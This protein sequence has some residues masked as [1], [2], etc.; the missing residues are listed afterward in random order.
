MA[1]QNITG[2]AQLQEFLNT[3]P[4]KLEK[5]IMRSALG[6]GARAMAK[7][8]RDRAPVGSPSSEGFLF[9]G[10]YAG[11]LRDSVRVYTKVAKDGR[12][13]AGIRVGG[14]NKKT[15]ADVFYAHIVEFGSRPHI[16]KARKGGALFIGG[17][18]IGEVMH[19]GT[20]PQPFVRPTFDAFAGEAIKA[21][22]AQVRKRLTKEG[23]NVPAPEVP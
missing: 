19:P 12:I 13:I 10:G 16:I 5:N 15:G 9:Y 4:A 22:A 2:G 11:A 20:R 1:D 21:V 3:L 6:A 23:I 8:I 17:N 18:L 7:E 14:K